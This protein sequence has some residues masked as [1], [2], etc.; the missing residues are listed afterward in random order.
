MTID[1]IQPTSK[2]GL[3]TIENLCLACRTCNEYKSDK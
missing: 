2:G 1:H 3:N